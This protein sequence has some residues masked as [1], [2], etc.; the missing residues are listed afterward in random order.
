MNDQRLIDIETKLAHQEILIS[1]LNQVIAT[2]QATIDQ[3]Q[4][5]LKG[6]FKRFREVN[7][8]DGTQVGPAGEKPPHY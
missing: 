7:G 8:E 4:A 2:Q 3:L 1:E 5:G 6:F